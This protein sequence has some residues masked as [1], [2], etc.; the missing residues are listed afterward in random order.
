MSPCWGATGAHA[1]TVQRSPSLACHT[2]QFAP[3]KSAIKISL[4]SRLLNTLDSKLFGIEILA[5]SILG[6]NLDKVSLKRKKEGGK[7]RKK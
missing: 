4:P 7:R 6:K 1:R 2:V 5:D 3:H